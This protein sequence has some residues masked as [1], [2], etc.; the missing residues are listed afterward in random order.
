MHMHTQKRSSKRAYLRIVVLVVASLL[1]A[2]C[3]GVG[4]SLGKV[5]LTEAELDTVVATYIYANKAEKVTAREVILGNGT[6]DAAKRD[7]GTYAVPA[8][9]TIIQYV[10][11]QILV[12]KAVS[13]GIEVS[14]EDVAAHANQQLGTADYDSIAAQYAMDAESVKA[15]LK[16]SCLM[17]K[18]REKVIGPQATEETADAPEAP[19]EPAQNG[20]TN[21]MDKKYADYIIKLA[22]DEWDAQ[23]GRWKSKDGYF[24]TALADYE[25]TNDGA[26]YEAAQAA[27][28]AAYQQYAES[29]G[30]FSDQWS[31]YVNTLFANA[32]VTVNAVIAE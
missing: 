12:S 23:A 29:E 24:A 20:A 28:Y 4:K 27:Y 10:Q 1:L 6:L 11:N 17:A 9:S 22:G 31:D 2:A 5:S 19:E 14:D 3:G 18:L 26:S 21:T 7:D 16:N 15:L 25:V 30:A 8:A 13:E 32:S